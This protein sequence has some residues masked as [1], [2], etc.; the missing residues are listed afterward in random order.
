MPVDKKPATLMA[1]VSVEIDDD[2][3]AE[4]ANKGEDPTEIIGWGITIAGEA[5]TSTGKTEG[6]VFLGQDGGHTSR[7]VGRWRIY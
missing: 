1:M 2:Y 4:I 5:H 6:P 7:H 3:L